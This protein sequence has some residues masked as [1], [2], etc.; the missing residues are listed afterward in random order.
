MLVEVFKTDV[1]EPLTAVMLIECL[2][3]LYPDARITFDLD[4]CDRIL[5]IAPK[6]M[7]IKVN[8]VIEL[9]QSHGRLIEVLE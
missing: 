9:V 5:R 6:V 4:D 8:Q 2:R 1:E 7:P 3:D